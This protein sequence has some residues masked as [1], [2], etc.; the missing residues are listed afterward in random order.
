MN[1]RFAANLTM[2]YN[3]V[4]FLERFAL[5]AEAGFTAVE[6]LFPYQEGVE[7]IRSRVDDLGLTVV[8]FD[9]PP[10]DIENGELG[11]L[12]NPLRRGYFR[13]SFV[14]ALGVADRLKCQRLNVLAGNKVDGLEHAA[15]IECAVENM[16]WAAPRAADAGVTLLIEPLNA[17]D[18]P[19]YLVHTTAAA[20]EIVRRANHP[21]VRLQYDVYH[22]QM[23]EGNLINTMSANF[24]FIAHVQIADVPDRHEPGTGEINYPAVFATLEALTYQGYIG[25]E[26]TPS[27]E[28][29]ASLGWM[30]ADLRK[31]A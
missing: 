27:R 9:V 28:T 24:P 31:R 13:Q 21:Q 25:L 7:E 5:A 15:Q 3:E 8:L 30:P 4:S 14:E 11:T 19:D 6:F 29:N 17:I 1:L 22:A 2:L 10:G 26:Y 20:M 23:E 12:S 18:R 16:A